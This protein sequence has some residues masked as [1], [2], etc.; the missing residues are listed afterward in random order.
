MRADAGGIR[1][2]H[3]K[4]DDAV[5]LEAEVDLPAC[6]RLRVMRPAETSRIVASATCERRGTAGRASGDACRSPTM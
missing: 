4:R 6:P 3:V 2:H 5:R 1:R